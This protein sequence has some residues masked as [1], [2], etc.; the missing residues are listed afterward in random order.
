MSI[1]TKISHIAKVKTSIFFRPLSLRRFEVSL[2][3]PSCKLHKTMPAGALSYFSA[4]TDTRRCLPCII[5]IRTWRNDVNNFLL[6]PLISIMAE[7]PFCLLRGRAGRSDRRERKATPNGV[8]DQMQKRTVG[9]LGNTP[10]S[11]KG[12][13]F[14]LLAKNHLAIRI[15]EAISKICPCQINNS[16]TFL[17]Q[18]SNI[19]LLCY[20]IISVSREVPH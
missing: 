6:P 2:H 8:F 11:R 16:Q 17:K 14:P 19:P 20:D 15:M 1:P 13:S 10:T 4:L 7:W 9:G 5:I 3:N 12:Y 18:K